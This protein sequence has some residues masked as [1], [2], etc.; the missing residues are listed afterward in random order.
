MYV[1]NTDYLISERLKLKKKVGRKS[2]IE[3]I[4]AGVGPT[5]LSDDINLFYNSVNIAVGKQGNGKTL[6]MLREIINIS[7][8][9]EE[10]KNS[11][12]PLGFHLIFYVNQSGEINDETF[13]I[14]QDLISIPIVVINYN[15]S[16]EVITGL[17]DFKQEYY[18]FIDQPDILGQWDDEKIDAVNE[19]LAVD[20]R[21]NKNLPK[22]LHKIIYFEDAA[23]QSVFKLNDSYFNKLAF[24]CRHN[25]TIFLF[26]VQ[27][28]AAISKP[29]LSQVTNV[30]IYPGYSPQEL[31][32][33]HRMSA[34]QGMDYKELKAV[35]TSL[36]QYQLLS[37]N[38]VTQVF[39][40]ID[41]SHISKMVNA[42]NGKIK[43]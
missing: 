11:P 21:K 30:F 22:T 38:M 40:I 1:S 8:L 37:A 20:I 17:L 18:K 36:K 35:Y 6:L 9:E 27:K 15:Q 10:F 34:I 26:C 25:N 28:M 16:E 19:A 39:A 29:I 3:P 23:N 2:L 32:Y 31:S 43:F 5:G 12:N 7:F 42:K 13:K 33:I 24:Q 14:L 41:L 4:A